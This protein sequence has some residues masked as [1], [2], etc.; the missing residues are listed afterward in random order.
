MTNNH[1]PGSITH[2]KQNKTIFLFRMIRIMD[3]QGLLVTENCFGFFK[4]NTVLFNVCRRF[5]LVPSES[6]HIYNII[7]L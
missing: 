3:Q 2:A 1:D 7:T 6:D 4:G 5:I